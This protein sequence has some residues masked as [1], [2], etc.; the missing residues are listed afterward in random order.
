MTKLEELKPKW[1]MRK[2]ERN[3]DKS[4]RAEKRMMAYHPH[5]EFQRRHQATDLH[6]G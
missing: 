1:P 5:M 6:L 4:G 2:D 3:G